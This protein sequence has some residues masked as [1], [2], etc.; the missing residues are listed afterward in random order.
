MWGAPVF[1]HKRNFEVSAWSGVGRLVVPPALG[2]A[3]PVVSVHESVQRAING[4][5]GWRRHWIAGL[6]REGWVCGGGCGSEL[7]ETEKNMMGVVRRGMARGRGAC[8]CGLGMG[9]GWDGKGHVWC[10]GVGLAKRERGT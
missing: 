3:S 9:F 1:G 2:V 10:R 5:A 4:A 7:G 8:G 6:A